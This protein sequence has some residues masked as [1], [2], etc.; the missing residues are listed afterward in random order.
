VRL[1]SREAS[2]GGARVWPE[3]LHQSGSHACRRSVKGTLCA[4]S[5][6]AYQAPKVVVHCHSDSWDLERQLEA[7]LRIG[8]VQLEDALGQPPG[9]LWVPRKNVLACG[10]RVQQSRH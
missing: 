6:G 10:S 3:A 4:A 9:G 2:W 8:L 1:Q 5:D 7:V